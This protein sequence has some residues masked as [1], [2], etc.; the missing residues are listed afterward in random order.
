MFAADEWYSAVGA[1]AVAALGYLEEGVVLG[2]GEGALLGEVVIVHFAPSF[3]RSEYVIYQP[4]PFMHA[5]PGIDFGDFLGKLIAVAFY[6]TSRGDEEP[7]FAVG[8]VPSVV[9]LFLL[10]LLEDGL[11]R[12]FFGVA[13]ESTSVE[14]NGLAVVLTTVEE[15]L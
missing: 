11:D 14:D 1:A 5:V 4:V 7:V 6:K 2:G 13:N 10:G 8:V 15:D 3:L 12:L 9:V